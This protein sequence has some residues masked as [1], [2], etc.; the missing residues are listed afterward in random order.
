MTLEFKFLIIIFLTILGESFLLENLL[1]DISWVLVWWVE[2][3]KRGW[4]IEFEW[5]IVEMKDYPVLG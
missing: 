4:L 5:G 1:D 3:P 2:A